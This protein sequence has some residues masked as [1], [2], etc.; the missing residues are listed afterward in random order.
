MAKDKKK[1]RKR[2][3]I[4]DPRKEQR[5]A[6]RERVAGE[7]EE[8]KKRQGLAETVAK[9]VSQIPRQPAQETPTVNDTSV[10]PKIVNTD[11][12]PDVNPTGYGRRITTPRTPAT[13]D[14]RDVAEDRATVESVKKFE[15]EPPKSDPTVI[16]TIMERRRAAKAKS[17]AT[18]ANLTEEATVSGVGSGEEPTPGQQRFQETQRGPSSRAGI[19]NYGR[20]ATPPAEIAPRTS[21]SRAEKRLKR[22]QPEGTDPEGNKRPILWMGVSSNP[23]VARTE[24]E[25]PRYEIDNTAR[26][27]AL[28]SLLDRGM[29]PSDDAVTRE[30]ITNTEH[31]QK[32]RVMTYT[33]LSHDEITNYLGKNEREARNRLSNLHEG[34]MQF[35]RARRKIEVHKDMG[36]AKTSEGSFVP[37]KAAEREFWQHP[38][39]TN[40]NGTPKV[41]RVSDMHPDMVKQLNDPSGWG[42]HRTTQEVEG[43]KGSAASGT[44]EP[45]VTH[46]GHH[47]T[48][49]RNREVWTFKAPP[50]GWGEDASLAGALKDKASLARMGITPN[51]STMTARVVQGYRGDID[52]LK[53]KGDDSKSSR[54]RHQDDVLGLLESAE[55]AH[56]EVSG[57]RSSGFVGK[58]K[59]AKGVPKVPGPGF[60]NVEELKPIPVGKV[61]KSKDDMFTIKGEGLPAVR[62]EQGNPKP[63]PPRAGRRGG[64][65]VVDDPVTGGSVQRRAV[66]VT[67]QGT[68]GFSEE[69]RRKVLA[70]RRSDEMGKMFRGPQPQGRQLSFD[71]G[72]N[73]PED[74]GAA[75]AQAEAKS[76]RPTIGVGTETPATTPPAKQYMIPFEGKSRQFLG[77]NVRALTEQEANVETAGANTVR[78]SNPPRRLFDVGVPEPT[79]ARSKQLP[80][81]E[82]KSLPLTGRFLSPEET[83]TKKPR[84]TSAK[85]PK[86]AK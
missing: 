27:L 58:R 41:Y 50:K 16:K 13:L 2:K 47:K 76:G 7:R 68:G 21:T 38:T 1:P 75:R 18:R 80:P 49:D 8:L 65:T 42:G 62:D 34:V 77:G 51:V 29:D 59:V 56:T 26:R 69:D 84:K 15:A 37:T 36:L 60:T 11:E 35:Q 31:E 46:F 17:D 10:T 55:T 39:E 33:G 57:K 54:Q 71:F 64:T 66:L 79:A 86:K 44:V 4:Q 43:T 45:V 48:G 23:P 74:T 30:L 25:E 72:V 9:N 24:D 52:V 19:V 20:T 82:S 63:L 5:K 81:K 14:P 6:G 85:A 67:Q 28:S 53:Q 12:E 70:G 73:I 83:A 32:A 22:R 3:G 78:G 61:K 40:P